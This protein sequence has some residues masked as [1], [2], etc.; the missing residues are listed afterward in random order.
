M[1]GLVM[2]IALVLTVT[3]MGFWSPE[4]TALVLTIL[5]AGLLGFIDDVAKVVFKRSLGLTPTAKLIFQ[6]I[7]ATVFILYS[8]NCLEITPNV[9]IPF[10]VDLDLGI[11]TTVLPIGEGITIPWLY[12]ILIDILLVGMCNACNLADGLDGLAAGSSVIIMIVMAAI[13]YRAD[14]LSCA[15]I[16]GALAGGCIGFL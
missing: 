2:L 15:I 6:F 1:G 9:T 16:S 11:F 10:I 14:S 13:S 8:I 5:A 7:I 3:I 12:L 4:V